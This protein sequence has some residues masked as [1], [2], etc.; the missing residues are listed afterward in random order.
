MAV[1]TFEKMDHLGVRVAFVFPAPVTLKA[2][3]EKLEGWTH[4]ANVPRYVSVVD[5][6]KVTEHVT[7][8]LQRMLYTVWLRAV[9][10][11]VGFRSSGTPA[12][13]FSIE[14]VTDFDERFD[15][16]WEEASRDFGLAVART[17]SYLT[18]RY[19]DHPD[20]HYRCLTAARSKALDAYV[21]L[22]EVKKKNVATWEL[23]ELI[24]DPEQVES[25][26]ALLR[27]IRNR[28][29]RTG[30][31]QLTT[32]MLPHHTPYIK[33]LQGAGFV[34]EESRLVPGHF[35]YAV[36]LVVRSPE[37]EALPVSAS[38]V[39]NWFVSMGDSDLH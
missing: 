26:L 13:D 27:A 9:G 6:A 1:Q 33:I 21:V 4:V 20:K 2:L 19:S 12:A 24:M 39:A 34:H 28:A 18:W 32:W 7:K 22:C 36:P 29:K 35:G 15:R 38:V 14:E 23:V 10:F 30:I 11:A 37:V 5:P 8:P 25:G 31:A 3:T 17:S 16:L